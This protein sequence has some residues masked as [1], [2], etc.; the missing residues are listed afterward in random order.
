MR[1]AG[2][3]ALDVENYFGQ[4]R[5]LNGP[6]DG[7]VLW[8]RWLGPDRYRT[9]TL[10]A[11]LQAD[12]RATLD[13]WCAHHDRAFLNKNNHNTACIE[14]LAKALERAHFVVVRRDLVQVAQSLLRAREAV[15]GDRRRGWGLWSTDVESHD[16]RAAM[17][18]VCEQVARISR[19]LRR[20]AEVVGAERLTVVDYDALC[21]S[22]AETVAD[23]GRRLGGLEPTLALR[24]LT[25]TD[26]SRL[27]PREL[28]YL[29][30]RLAE[31]DP[32]A[33]PGPSRP[34]RSP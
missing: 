21:R 30:G 24:P 28:D 10:E 11:P 17:D 7:F 13:A 1:S 16:P 3:P 31:L 18:A 34:A 22:P 6:N 2:A 25:S 5:A 15:H 32:D 29:R 27:P 23:L 12:M 14:A 26:G 20:C 9:A 19:H 8:N 33:N 4:T